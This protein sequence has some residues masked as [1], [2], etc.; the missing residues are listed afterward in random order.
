MILLVLLIPLFPL[1]IAFFSGAIQAKEIYVASGVRSLVLILF[2]AMAL[3][4]VAVVVPYWANRET[5]SYGPS[6]PFQVLVYSNLIVLIISKFATKIA[7]EQDSILLKGIGASA[8][9][10]IPTTFPLI[11]VFNN[12][13]AAYFDITFTV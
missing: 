7:Q 6:I 8:M 2:L 11:L 12:F 5:A 10:A 3:A 4:I 1:V 9:L 13:L